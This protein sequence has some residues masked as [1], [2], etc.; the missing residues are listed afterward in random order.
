MGSIWP[1]HAETEYLSINTKI[2]KKILKIISKNQRYNKN[3]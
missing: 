1:H 2:N 3:I